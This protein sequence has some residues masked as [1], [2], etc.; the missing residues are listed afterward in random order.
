VR[1]YITTCTAYLIQVHVPQVCALG[2]V[3]QHTLKNTATALS[4]AQT[5]LSKGSPAASHST[6]EHSI[7]GSVTRMFPHT[8]RDHP[9]SHMHH[10][11][12]H[13]APGRNAHA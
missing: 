8:S 12:L 9:P 13:H 3:D 10:A 7:A 5:E 11:R 4:T 2:V 6:A 1:N